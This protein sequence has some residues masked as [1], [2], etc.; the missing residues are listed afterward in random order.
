MYDGTKKSTYLTTQRRPDPKT[1]KPTDKPY[2]GIVPMVDYEKSGPVEAIGQTFTALYNTVD[3][4][5]GSMTSRFSASG[6]NEYSGIVANGEY[7]RQDRPSSVAG[8]VNLGGQAVDQD[9]WDLLRLMAVINIFLALFNLLPILPL[10]GGHAAI[11]VYE[12]VAS[13]IMKRRI[14]ANHKKLIP[15]ATAFIGFV[16]LLSLSTLWLDILQIA[17]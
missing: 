11:A 4:S 5:I 13:K 16:L 3:I 2:I 8:I 14:K 10:D 7:E 1:N 6:L 17:S 9:I 12:W 15:I